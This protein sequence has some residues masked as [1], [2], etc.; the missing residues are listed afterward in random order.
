[1]ASS[2]TIKWKTWAPALA[3]MLATA[4]LASSCGTEVVKYDAFYLRITSEA[5]ADGKITRLDI[6]LISAKDAEGEPIKLTSATAENADQFSFPL[7]GSVDLVNSPYTVRFKQAISQKLMIRILGQDDDL[8]TLTA[9][10]GEIDTGFINQRDVK[11]LA[12]K[13]ECDADG[14][15]VRNCSN[16][17][18]NCPAG[19]AND[20]ND[21]KATGKDASPF[22][23]E[24]PCTQCG[25]K[26]DE[27]CDGKDLACVDTDK[28]GVPDCLET[29]CGPGAEKDPDVYPG[30]PEV[31]D[32]KD[33]D[34][35]GKVDEA[36]KGLTYIGIDGV[37]GTKAKGD[38]CGKGVC[39]GGK[40]IC[41]PKNNKQMICDSASKKKPK[42]ICEGK[43]DKGDDD[44]NGKIND[45]CALADI[46][47]DGVNNDKEKVC[48][49]K[50][51]H[52]YAD[53]HPGAPE[54]CCVAYSEYIVSKNPK[55]EDPK[56]IPAGAKITDA[57]L[58]Q[59]DFNC[60]G[61]VD[62][63]HPKDADGDGFKAG[64]DCDDNNP[65]IHPKPVFEKCGD[66][67]PQS[68]TGADTPCDPAKDKDGDGWYGG[69]GDCDD[70][71][72][73]INPEAKEVCDGIDNDCDGLFDEGN[74]EAGGKS[75]AGSA[76]LDKELTCGDP[77]GECG[78]QRGI[79][80]CKHWPKGQDPGK[81]DCLDKKFDKAGGTCVGCEGDKRPVEDSAGKGVDV[82]D[83]LDNDCDGKSDEDWKYKEEGTGNLLGIGKAC[84]G[85]GSCG[86]G[87]VECTPTQNKATCSTDPD[88]SK[89][90]NNP[91]G[92][93]NKDNDCDGVTDEDL[94][95]VT[96]SKCSKVGVC[97]GSAVQK[98]KTV[99]VAGKWVC[100]YASVTGFQYD[101]T[102][103][104][105]PGSAFC[106]CPNLADKGKVCFKMVEKTC[107]GLDNDCSG[108][109]DEEFK[110]DDL[111]ALKP[112]GNGCGTGDCT[113]GKV[114]C[115][116]AGKAAT[117]STLPK[118]TVEVC[119][120]KDN[121]CN[122]KIDD[123]LNIK[124][125]GVTCKLKGLCN[126]NNVVGQCI[127]GGWV[128][129]YKGV[130]SG[131]EGVIEK[132]CDDKDND[133]D[134][135]VD[136]DFKFTDFNGKKLNVGVTCGTGECKGGNVVC[137]AK[138]AQKKGAEM[139][140]STLIKSKTDIC[141]YLDNDCD[142]KSDE[143][144]SWLGLKIGQPCDGIGACG[145]GKVE[146]VKG[147]T[148]T[149]TCSTN[150]NGTAKQNA[151]EV[152]DDSDN[153]C[154]GKTDE[155]C[156]DDNDEYCETGL[157]P[158]SKP[159]LK[160]KV[161]PKGGGDCN[162]DPV[163]GKDFN[164][165]VKELCNGKDD[166][167]SG[168]ADE[169]FKYSQ[170][171]AATGK[172]A[173]LS[174]GASCGLGACSG[175]KVKCDG[176]TKATCDSLGKLSTEVCDGIDNNCDGRVDEGC[177]DDGDGYCDIKMVV[178]NTKAC[179]KTKIKGGKG[180]DC[181]DD[182]STGAK[183]NPGATEICDAIDNN[184]N[185]AKDEGCDDDGDNFCD[186]KMTVTST[187]ACVLTKP[188]N[189][190]GDDCDDKQTKI[191]PNADEICD[192]VDNQC[193]A[194]VD[195]GCDDDGDGFC[196][197]KMVVTNTKACSKTTIKSGKGDDCNDVKGPGDNV[198]PGSAEHC[199]N[200][201]QNCNGAKD[202]GCDDDND[203]WCDKNY[204]VV[205]KPAICGK[206]KGD[207]NDNPAKN[208]A[209]VNP[210][211]TEVCNLVDDD[212]DG[213]TDAKD[214][215]AVRPKCEK[216]KGVC[217]GTLKPIALCV[218]GKWDQCTQ[219]TY[220]QLK[221][222]QYNANAIEPL[223]DGKDND[224]NGV[225]D[226][227]C[228]ADNDDWCAKGKTVIGKPPTCKKGAGDCDDSKKSVHPGAN[229]VCNFLDD[230]CAG[231]A[232]EGCDDD[233]DGYCDKNMAA[234]N[235][236]SCPKTTI[237]GGMGDDCNDK[238][239]SFHPKA[240]ELC[241]GADRNCDGIKDN[242]CDDDKD[243]YCDK[244]KLITANAKC[245]KSKKPPKGA[246]Y[247]D[248]CND[249][250]KAINPG[251]K[252]VCDG[253]VDENCNG[254]VDEK[255]ANGC[256]KYYVDDDKDGFGEA[257]SQAF[258]MCKPNSGLGL[259]AKNAVDCNDGSKAKASHT[260]T[261]PKL[262]DLQLNANCGAGVCAGGKVVCKSNAATCNTAHKL[263][264][265]TCNGADDN[266][267]GKVDNGLVAAFAD[268]QDGVCSGAKK[269]C[270]GKSGW[271]EPDYTKISGYVSKDKCDKTDRNCNGNAWDSGAQGCGNYF[272]KKNKGVKCGDPPTTCYCDGPGAP[273][274][275]ELAT[276]TACK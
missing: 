79:R 99:C 58:A 53:Y 76:A 91:E 203:G 45:G 208:G 36:D 177:D 108:Q 11:L 88:G 155:A 215:I 61:K 239:P 20:C 217:A 52:F 124:S 151:G 28:D 191:N 55:W 225:V 113:G 193:N 244:K 232:D 163:K 140:C 192:G 255:N 87:K 57:L 78:K 166:N 48:A 161:C 30:A 107:D 271:V 266:C 228:D 171:N 189:G 199:D 29:Q 21:D 206:G 66:G 257:G 70:D 204:L 83:Y 186:A 236:K 120:K 34:C 64:A 201:D 223:C 274:L 210:G 209:K 181:N 134:G 237:K 5:P 89:K 4:A 69:A 160:T 139:T 247:G 233:K 114:I 137:K 157:M 170:K 150:P 26:I 159:N 133:C 131:Y 24:D 256:K 84:D 27:D 176:M 142:G 43:D 35:D 216:Q 144:Y 168:I 190:K 9:W 262:G 12:P 85:I 8:K 268:K 60:D 102:K 96:A 263:K 214:N 15:G 259:T 265:E 141:D 122:G 97:A 103:T 95:A 41:D 10:S 207:C 81:Y 174:I 194:K 136:E 149:A 59:C 67:V 273:G 1:M 32:N 211:A 221:G 112:I 128:C 156:D 129:D 162:D 182:K 147:K 148:D 77:D 242:G 31:C 51:A 185:G 175:G 3:A 50:Y 40:V 135:K 219:A 39:D 240:N 253:K 14:D 19:E 231:G 158:K 224:C 116:K 73:D 183:V 94:T 180:D 110:Y 74:P 200:I 17:A 243:G 119:D 212:C 172:T 38:D 123:G 261:D 167:C 2:A 98:I 146:C 106:H 117:C 13:P 260:Y 47:G 37:G 254:D 104:C 68:C 267:D 138:G 165:G 109:T 179:A 71:N 173:T 169:P 241:D 152:C 218:N 18:C 238:H 250:K 92:C 115:N 132:T 246:I 153:D 126:T 90:Q 205:G 275:P 49:F 245:T 248:D 276:K 220:K 251:A 118:I 63:C 249:G 6:A 272:T 154:D 143:D 234:T 105:T 23:F 213:K 44:C 226:T 93:D 196:D 100:N 198:H 75:A 25:N 229:E 195:E 230:N 252:E 7:P 125:K 54:G 202:E 82:C 188:I 187:E 269:V 72:K 42:E 222:A 164:P 33:N 80:V 264:A 65:L 22:A 101:T 127:Q 86:K 16:E 270:Q 178:K 56:N 130:G 145:N 258:C 46:D 184:C 111:G 235:T 197:A 62:P 227:S 121:D